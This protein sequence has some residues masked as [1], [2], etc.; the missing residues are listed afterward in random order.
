MPSQFQAV[1]LRR[2]S[3]TGEDALAGDDVPQDAADLRLVLKVGVGEDFLA[4]KKRKIFLE[5]G[6]VYEFGGKVGGIFWT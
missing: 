6:I 4:R 5:N 2:R 3:V 1:G